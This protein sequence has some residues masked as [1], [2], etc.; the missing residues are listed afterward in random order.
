MV[1]TSCAVACSQHMDCLY[2]EREAKNANT[3]VHQM[4][5]QLS[6]PATC[7]SLLT[8]KASTNAMCSVLSTPR[9]MSDG[10]ATVAGS[11]LLIGILLLSAGTRHQDVCIRYRGC[12][13]KSK[14]VCRPQPMALMEA[15]DQCCCFLRL[16]HPV[17]QVFSLH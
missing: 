15:P 7:A 10:C 16:E 6:W 12:L 4:M 1:S 11:L 14:S 5:R 17:Q 3:Q 13:A 8:C 9:L 2:V